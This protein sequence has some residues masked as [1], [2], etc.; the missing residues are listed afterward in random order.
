MR[1]SAVLKNYWDQ[2]LFRVPIVP[3]ERP[4]FGTELVIFR[5]TGAEEEDV[6][7]CAGPDQVRDQAHGAVR[8]VHGPNPSSQAA[9]VKDLC[10]NTTATGFTPMGIRL[11][12]RSAKSIHDGCYIVWATW[13]HAVQQGP[14]RSR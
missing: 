11:R 1:N 5:R 6:T 2:G 4:P 12:W 13:P 7:V 8:S 10:I 3:K 14:G 9:V